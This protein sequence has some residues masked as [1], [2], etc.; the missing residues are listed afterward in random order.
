M[1]I[2]ELLA[3]TDQRVISWQD[4]TLACWPQGSRQI[5]WRD[6][7]DQHRATAVFDQDYEVL[8]LELIT[9]PDRS[10][11]WTD[12]R[13]QAELAASLGDQDTAESRDQAQLFLEFLEAL[14]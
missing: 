11:R 12:P 2:W 6:S 10:L 13:Y 1:T 9:A 3:T 7:S 14:R 4:A 8:A 5:Y